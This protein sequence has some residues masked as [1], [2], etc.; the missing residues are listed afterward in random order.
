MS[1]I[2]S[3]DNIIQIKCSYLIEKYQRKLKNLKQ[4]KNE[5]KQSFEKKQK[6]YYI[7][8]YMFNKEKEQLYD[9]FRKRNE[10]FEFERLKKTREL[11]NTYFADIF[12]Y[13]QEYYQ[14]IYKVFKSLLLK[15]EEIQEK[16]KHVIKLY[17]WAHMI[18][19]DCNINKI[20]E[21]KGTTISDNIAN[22]NVYNKEVRNN[23]DHDSNKDKKSYYNNFYGVDVNDIYKNNICDEFN[24]IPGDMYEHKTNGKSIDNTNLYNEPT[25]VLNN[26]KVYNYL[27]NNNSYN[28]ISEV[29]DSSNVL[30]NDAEEKEENEQF[31]K[32]TEYLD[33][34]IEN[35]I[36]FNV[37]S[38]FSGNYEDVNLTDNKKIIEEKYN[39]VESVFKNLTRDEDSKNK[40]EYPMIDQ[41]SEK[42]AAEKKE[43]EKKEAEKKEAEKK[44]AEKKEAEKKAAEKKEAEKKEAEKKE[45][46]KKAAEKKE[47]EKKAAE[48]K[49][50][51]K[52]AAEKKEA[53]KKAAEKKEPGKRSESKTDIK[54]KYNNKQNKELNKREK[55]INKK[56]NIPLNTDNNNNNKDDDDYNYMKMFNAK[57]I[58]EDSPLYKI[59][60][61]I[62]KESN[63]QV[64]GMNIFKDLAK[65][66]PNT[67]ET[68]EDLINSLGYV[69][70]DNPKNNKFKI[71]D[72]NNTEFSNIK[73]LFNYIK[74]NFKK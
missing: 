48:K 24:T 17:D 39:N 8:K 18:L 16:E 41:Q 15:R 51:E 40:I 59:I 38:Y 22:Y 56:I 12:L 72:D 70:K 74:S 44:E 35:N 61:N 28:N 33:D 62:N 37:S 66:K 10:E 25:N 58:P 54:N 68:Y 47:V 21:L 73:D 42:K 55:S 57:N 45:S 52:K 2:L 69:N 64:D 23:Y 36:I 13:E 31:Q 30:K 19:S 4:F 63:I 43:A 27:N 34:V 46:E 29:V 49:E 60:H 50:A 1:L 14:C 65:E 3:T 9:E 67:L 32:N 20:G 7:E 5:I 6:A 11:Y 26:D 53:E 71:T